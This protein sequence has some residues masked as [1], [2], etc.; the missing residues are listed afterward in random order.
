MVGPLNLAT[1]RV[2]TQDMRPIVGTAVLLLTLLAAVT[3]P[4][5]SPAAAAD[6][7]AE[8][9]FLSLINGER[10]RHG[11]APLSVRGEVVP[12]ARSWSDYMARQGAIS[13]NPDLVEQMPSDWLRLGENVGVGG[14]VEGLHR[15]FMDSPGHRANVLGD[16]N[17]AGIGVSYGPRGM[18]VTVD[19][20]KTAL[21]QQTVTAAAPAPSTTCGGNI[22]PPA[23]PSS[24]AAAGYWVL[25]T[26]GGIFSY[27]D[28]PFYGSVPG[29]G[30]QATSVLMAATPS[31][32]GYWILGTDG[33][34]FSFGDAAF[35]GSLP[36]AGVRTTAIDL[37]P[38][39]TGNGYWVLGADGGIFSFGDAAF[40]GSLPGAGVST[41][42]VKL[43]PTPS[44][45]GYWV[46]GA[47]GGIFSFGDAAFH[48][49][50]PGAGVSNRSISMAPTPRGT[51][52]WVLGADGGIFS[53][54]DAAFYGSVPGMGMCESVTGIQ[55]APTVTGGGYYVLSDRGGVF[56]FGDAPNHGEPKILA[57]TA[58]DIAVAR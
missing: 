53:F 13:H 55:L 52:Y 21:V 38:T 43:V 17:Q 30:V 39:G 15:A 16:F 50:L 20:M 25:G 37:K 45:N 14:S 44:G 32:H 33:G 47:D 12:A 29:A 28:T 41:Q 54:G 2:E 57:I 7:V 6:G 48:G 4:L 9:E 10:S 51:G 5:A 40:Y 8:A 26:D 46:L 22:N 18:F 35:H 24:Q 19:F 27:G 31:S 1:L 11:K 23:A 3:V 36:G 42:A 34:I 56:S 58:R 49:S